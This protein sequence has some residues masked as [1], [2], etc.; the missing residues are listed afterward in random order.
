[1]R[2][3]VVIVTWLLVFAAMFC[4]SVPAET[5]AE[6]VLG[7]ETIEAK[8]QE[9]SQSVDSSND[10][11]DTA[12]IQEDSQDTDPLNDT[13]DADEVQEGAQGVDSPGD[14]E[15]TE[16]LSAD[17]LPEFSLSLEAERRIS[18]KIRNIS[19]EAQKR[20][21]PS[22]TFSCLFGYTDQGIDDVLP[23]HF[24]R[25][26][27]ISE[28]VAFS[29]RAGFR[30][31][32]E[33]FTSLDGGKFVDLGD[34]T[35]LNVKVWKKSGP[36]Y[37]AVQHRWV[38][39]HHRA[40]QDFFYADRHRTDVRVGLVIGPLQPYAF[41]ASDLPAYTSIDDMAVYGGGGFDLRFDIDQLN[42]GLYFGASIAE[43]LYLYNQDGRALYRVRAGFATSLGGLVVNPEALFLRGVYSPDSLLT[44]S[45][46][47]ALP[48]AF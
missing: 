43:A 15:D 4:F 25:G 13:E 9:D 7:A 37:G 21:R 41:V 36:L 14:I 30:I 46:K 18:A 24:F 1:M 32:I 27:I 17:P 12:E 31:A 5:S 39:T 45:F 23:E 26:H 33:N 40:T 34:R 42:T 38:H 44:I 20:E 16:E 11:R 19:E 29:H 3:L 8:I 28:G 35:L 48:I 2:F 22:Y 10:T 6:E 47:I